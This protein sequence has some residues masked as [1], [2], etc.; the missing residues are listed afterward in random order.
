MSV[1]PSQSIQSRPIRI[2][3]FF[4]RP[5]IIVNLTLRLSVGSLV[6]AQFSRHQEEQEKEQE[7]HIIFALSRLHSQDPK[8][9][10]ALEQQIERALSQRR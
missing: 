4:L 9:L 7:D 5:L 10:L 8:P 2:E 3:P 6:D 1:R